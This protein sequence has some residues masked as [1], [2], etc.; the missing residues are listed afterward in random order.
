MKYANECHH[1]EENYLF[2]L[3]VYK[4]E[5]VDVW[6]VQRPHQKFYKGHIEFCLR[7]GNGCDEYRSSWDC[8]TIE[9]CLDRH[10]KLAESIYKRYEYSRDNLIKFKQKLQELDCWDADIDLSPEITEVVIP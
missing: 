6:I 2:T 7:Y 4:G 10:T 8:N 1:P 3:E 5:I 9:R